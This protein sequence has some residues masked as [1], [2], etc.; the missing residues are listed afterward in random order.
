M[1]LPQAG[2]N[3]FPF[4]VAIAFSPLSFMAYSIMA[5]DIRLQCNIKKM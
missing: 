2:Q 3:A 4:G 1:A 5:N